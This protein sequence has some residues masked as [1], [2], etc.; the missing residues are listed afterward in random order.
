MLLA[1]SAPVDSPVL[2]ESAL[3][4]DHAPEARQ[5]VALVDDQVSIE[6]PPLVTDAGFAVSD[7]VGAD[8]VPPPELVN[9][10]GS[11]APPQAAIARANRGTSSRV[12]IRKIRIPI[13]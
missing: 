10:T 12:L 11:P 6:E 13:P 4:P 1:V 9:A 5:E 7:R 3:L 8:G 2:L